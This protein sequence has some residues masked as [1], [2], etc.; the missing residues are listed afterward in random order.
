[1]APLP[2]TTPE[3]YK[4][5]LYRL[6]ELEASK[7]NMV[8]CVKAFFAFNDFR[9]SEDG[10][11]DGYMVVFDMKGCTLAHLARVSTVMNLVRIFMLYIQVDP[12]L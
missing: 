11:V 1:M 9:I 2:E 7:L 12:F 6:K 8:E 3:N 5:I 4:I 10:L